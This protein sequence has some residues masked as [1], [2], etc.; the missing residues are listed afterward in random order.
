MAE[1]ASRLTIRKSEILPATVMLLAAAGACL[2]ILCSASITARVGTGIF[3]A[4]YQFL[5][6]VVLGSGVTAVFQTL[7]QAR[8]ARERRKTLQRE[9]HGALI[10]GYNDAKRVRRLLRARARSGVDANIID[11][12]EYDTQL[13]A[14]SSAQLSIEFATRR[15][16]LNR[17][18]FPHA[19]DLR[20]ALKAVGAYLNTI[21]DEWEDLR[22]KS[23]AATPFIITTLPA[24]DAFLRHY[25]D[26]PAFR[27]G[28]KKPFDI[29]LRLIEEA[30][31]DDVL[32]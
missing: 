29:A 14:L 1:R 18:V 4:T 3:N 2:F 10:T 15:I 30:L 6:V 11:R 8:D 24:L 20:A 22:P 27:D 21:V 7:A 31:A 9:I 26:S 12:G 28:F 23:A 13:E 17:T 19:E 16:E 25:N 5:L 32:S